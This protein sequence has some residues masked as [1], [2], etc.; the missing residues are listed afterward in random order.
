[1]KTSKRERDGILVVASFKAPERGMMWLPSLW[2]QNAREREREC[3]MA[4]ADG[5]EREE[6][7]GPHS[8][9]A[10]TGRE[11]KSSSMACQLHVVDSPSLKLWK[12]SFW[13]CM[14][15]CQIFFFF[16]K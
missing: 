12:L 11:R 6:K 3:G 1:M 5:P 10:N 9:L 15:A 16:F 4:S 8:M 2:L 7:K 13:K 14:A